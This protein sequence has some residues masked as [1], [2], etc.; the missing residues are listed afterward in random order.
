MQYTQTKIQVRLQNGSTLTQ[1]F[2]VK[3]QLAAVRLFIQMNQGNDGP[4]GL[5]TSFP[6]KVFTLE[7]Y[8]TPLEVLGLIPSAVVIVVKSP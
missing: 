6:R 1:T 3:E 7:D 5:M 2:D 8:D 4:F